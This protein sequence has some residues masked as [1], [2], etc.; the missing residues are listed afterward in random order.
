[1]HKLH[2]LVASEVCNPSVQLGVCKL[3]ITQLYSDKVD[4]SGVEF[5]YT[6]NATKHRA[7]VLG[8]G[9][10]VTPYM[11]I[12][13]KANEFTIY[14]MCPSECTQRVSVFNSERP[15]RRQLRVLSLPS[16]AVLPT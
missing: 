13:P 1:M 11:V 14:G 4:S 16:C 7:G 8:V 3:Y 9:D 15:L 2:V 5:F 10:S 6:S 12:P